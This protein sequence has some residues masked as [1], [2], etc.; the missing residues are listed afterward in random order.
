M[1]R[2]P[3]PK[4]TLSAGERVALYE[5][6]QEKK[7]QKFS[8]DTDDSVIADTDVKETVEAPSEN[9]ENTSKILPEAK[10]QKPKPKSATVKVDF[11]ISTG[12]VKP[13]HGMCNGPVSYGADLSEAF[14]EIGVPIVRFDATDTA[15]SRCAVDISRIFKNPDADPSDPD[16][17]DFACTDKYVDAAMYSGAKVIYRLGES[18]DLLGAVQMNMMSDID[19][20]S[21]ICV[22]VIRHYN[23][24]WAQGRHYGIKYFE[25]LNCPEGKGDF[26]KVFEIYKRLANAVKLYDEDIKV[27]GLSFESFADAKELLRAAKKNRIPLDFITV[28]CFS[29]DPL[30]VR[31]DA[32]SLVA[33][34]RNQ[35][36]GDVEIIVG[37]W[38]FVDGDVLN[39]DDAREIFASDSEKQRKRKKEIFLS[40]RSIKGA[41]FAAANMLSMNQIDGISAACFYDAQPTVSPFCALTDRYGDVEKPFYAFRAFGELYRAGNAVLCAV[42]S[43]DDFAHSGIFASAAV[44]GGGEGYVMIASFGGC[45]VVDLRLDGVSE[46]VYSADVYMLDGVKN[47]TLA[48]T[49]PVS[50]LKK[51]LVLSVS[52]YGAV[53]VK[54]Y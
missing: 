29:S 9:A 53:L 40:Q 44:S 30:S 14:R 48:D 6:E 20:L 37:K 13:M 52:E 4:N 28:D 15:M 26:S 19:A 39:G 25:L 2:R 54:L 31:S 33:F 18:L 11:S 7:R 12:K 35:G 50:G 24:G 22:N 23:D 10:K 51:R 5:A 49:V 3:K 21:R 46:N 1:P 32:E 38:A 45:G 8:V 41:A 47:M 42:E 34:A 27:G 16:S 17:Y 43:P 36:V